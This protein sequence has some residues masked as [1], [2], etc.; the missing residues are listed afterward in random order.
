MT[1]G[2]P[3]S[4]ILSSGEEASCRER[5]AAVICWEGF[6]EIRMVLSVLPDM[7]RRLSGEK[8]TPITR[9]VCPVS[10]RPTVRPV[11]EF[12]THTVLS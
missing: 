1:E 10:G 9:L 4:E 11:S 5:G 12:Q 3:S 8:E 7:K 2:W 6:C